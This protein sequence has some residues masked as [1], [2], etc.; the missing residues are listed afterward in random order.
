MRPVLSALGALLFIPMISNRKF[1]LDLGKDFYI[2]DIKESKGTAE[3]VSIS[4]STIIMALLK[5]CA[6]EE[7]IKDKSV[8]FQ[9]LCWQEM[10]LLVVL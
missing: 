8:G 7:T 5:D 6:N 10:A 3:F 1:S 9:K 4:I 2:R